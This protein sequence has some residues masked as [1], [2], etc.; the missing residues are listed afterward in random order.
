M[1]T[2]SLSLSCIQI[3]EVR[4]AWEG[5]GGTCWRL[6]GWSTPVCPSSSVR[7]REGNGDGR[8]RTHTPAR[9][10]LHTAHCTKDRH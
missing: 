6:A 7:T 1:I 8:A 9:C 3:P 10:T 5:S 2:C 4:E